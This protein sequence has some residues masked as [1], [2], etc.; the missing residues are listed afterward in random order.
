MMEK[1]KFHFPTESYEL[2]RLLSVTM[3][4]IR[5]ARQQELT[6]YGINSKRVSLLLSINIFSRC[7]FS[8]DPNLPLSDFL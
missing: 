3:N 7:K 6:Q 1:A 8:Y 4:A 5:R 2:S